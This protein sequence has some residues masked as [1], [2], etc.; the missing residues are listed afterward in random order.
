MMKPICVPCGRFYRLK[1]SGY[2]F[3]EGMPKF[4]DA[5]PGHGQPSFWQPYKVW[6]GDLWHCPGC[7]HEIIHGTG[8]GPISEHYKPDFAQCVATLHADQFTVNDC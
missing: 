1:R 6:S 8:R 7:N 2:Y 3:I 5:E 4:R